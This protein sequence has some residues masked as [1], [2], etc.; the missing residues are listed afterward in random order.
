M[1]DNVRPQQHG[2]V[3]SL[4]ASSNNTELNHLWADDSRL[5]AQEMAH[6]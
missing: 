2:P 4:L 5:A 3:Q 6:I 1:V